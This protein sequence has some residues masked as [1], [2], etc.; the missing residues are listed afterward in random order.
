M[1]TSKQHLAPQAKFFYTRGAGLAEIADRLGLSESTLYRWKAEDEEAG[2]PWEGLR[3]AAR[4]V[5]APRLVLRL[6]SL[7]AEVCAD[8]DLAPTQRVYVL[9]RVHPILRAERAR[10]R[11]GRVE[12]FGRGENGHD[13]RVS[14]D[15]GGC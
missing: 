15:P 12:H 8:E 10:L 6:E 11:D 13:E 1:P 5:S 3:E 7:I 4:A 14:D 2:E 9:R